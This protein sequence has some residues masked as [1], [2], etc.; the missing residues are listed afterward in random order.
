MND[1]VKYIGNSRFLTPKYVNTKILITAIGFDSEFCK[2]KLRL[3]RTFG[4]K[5]FIACPYHEN[6]MKG[7]VIHFRHYKRQN[8]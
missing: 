1:F 4:Q 7:V 6:A 5:L 8:S 2:S 3:L